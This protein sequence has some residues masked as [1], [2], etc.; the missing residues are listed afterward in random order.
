MEFANYFDIIIIAIVVILAFKGLFSGFI[1]EI[2]SVVGI[3]GGVL[4]ASRFNIDFGLW[5]NSFLKLES[6]TLL[7][8]IGFMLILGAIWILSLIL[9]EV[10]VR[11]AKFIKLGKLDKILGVIVAGLKVF[12]IVSI[13]LFTFSKI[14]FLSNFTNKLQDSSFCYPL[15]VKIGD[16]IVKTDFV[17]EMKDGAVNFGNEALEEIQS[18]LQ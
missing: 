13:I 8:L 16:F 10:V 7:N 2:F 5:I 15:M 11:F 14:N 18:T 17:S 6:Q 12:L 9:A 1:R 3:V 4:V